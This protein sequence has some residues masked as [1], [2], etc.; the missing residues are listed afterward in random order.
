MKDFPILGMPQEKYTHFKGDTPINT[1]IFDYSWVDIFRGGQLPDQSIV[2]DVD[3]V[4]Q[5]ID[6]YLFI[7]RY[8]HH[9][10]KTQN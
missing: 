3:F 1:V 5:P 9:I 6:G 2:I 8:K 10:A 7:Q 4:N